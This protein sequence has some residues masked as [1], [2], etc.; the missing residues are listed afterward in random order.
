MRRYARAGLEAQNAR[1]EM[2]LMAVRKLGEMINEI[3]K[4]QGKR[5]DLTS[6]HY[7]TK[8]DEAEPDRVKRH[9]WQKLAEIPQETFELIMTRAFKLAL[10]GMLIKPMRNCLKFLLKTCLRSFDGKENSFSKS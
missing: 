3:E 10:Y 7:V 2:H 5:T 4:E 6:L 9:R 8:L 1:V